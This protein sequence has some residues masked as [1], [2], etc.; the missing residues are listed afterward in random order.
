MK[1]YAVFVILAIAFGFISYN[2]NPK[3]YDFDIDYY[4]VIHRPPQSPPIQL[5]DLTSDCKAT[6]QYRHDA[7]RTG[8]APDSTRPQVEA[9]MIKHLKPLN[10][11]I[12]TAS[13]STPTI[14]DTGV[15]VGSDAGWFFKYDHDG[16]L[17]WKFSVPGSKNGIH[18][19]A[20]LDQKKVYIGAYNGF[21]YALDKNN[22][23]VVWANPV[24]DYIGASPLLANGSLY[25]SAETSHPDGLLAKLDC[26]SGRTLWVSDWLEGHSHSSPAYDPETKRILV[27]ANSGK[28]FAFE[29]KDGSLAW[30]AQLDGQNKGT[31]LIWQGKVYFG[32]WDKSYY[33]Y[34]IKT[35]KQIWEQFM[36]G[37][38]QTSLTLVPGE[39]IGITNTKV[40]QIIGIGID[41]ESGAI[42]WRLKHGDRNNQYSILVTKKSKEETYLAWSRCKEYQ[43]C[44]LNAKTG[45][46]LKNTQ[47]PG[48]YSG[49]P[50]AFN[51]R[52]YISLD[53]DDGFVIFQ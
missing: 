31:P 8:V 13:K 22:G 34:D 2:A 20:A 50:F 14:D 7:Q 21:M 53:R 10:V 29:E 32:S 49:V 42:L 40:G 41:L 11:D 6:S 38:I 12:H 4:S 16:N 1:T 39:G 37:R 45:A 24:G 33:A 23:S 9:K 35:G 48:S 15:Y 46:L 5:K 28:F 47:L 19:S 51:D 52:V 30:S 25:I 17:L 27:G 18:G 43:L 3:G 44:V 26:N 36:G